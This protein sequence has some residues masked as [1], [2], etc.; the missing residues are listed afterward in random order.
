MPYMDCKNETTVD[1]DFGP[2][3]IDSLIVQNEYIFIQVCITCVYIY[4]IRVTLFFPDFV[5]ECCRGC[6][7]I[8]HGEG[9]WLRANIPSYKMLGLLWPWKQMHTV[10]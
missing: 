5:Y 2:I 1:P 9:P 8:G 7:C 10:S 6:L 4:S 3:D